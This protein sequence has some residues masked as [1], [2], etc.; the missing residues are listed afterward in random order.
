MEVGAAVIALPAGTV[1]AVVVVEKIT[2]C[3]INRIKVIKMTG[4][5]TLS[6]HGAGC[7]NA[8]GLRF[9]LAQAAAALSVVCCPLSINAG[10][11]MT[12]FVRHKL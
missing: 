4:S 3:L 11:E 5:K 10:S 6:Y 12:P 9:T 2:V 1:V 8:A 7:G